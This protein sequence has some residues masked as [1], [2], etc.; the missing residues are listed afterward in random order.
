M[1]KKKFLVY[2]DILGFGPLAA[3]IA[4][5]KGIDQRMVRERFIEVIKGKIE[6]LETKEKIIGKKY[7]NSDDWIL[8]TDTLDKVF[9]CIYEIL[10]H[11]TGYISYEKIPLEIAMGIGGFDKWARFDGKN[12]IGEDSA[13]D[14]LKTDIIGHYRKWYKKN[15]N[16]SPKSTFIILTESAY[17][18][19]EPLDKKICQQIENKRDQDKEKIITFFGADVDKV[20]RGGKAYEFLEKI[21]YPGNK[22]YGKIDELYVPPFE[23]EDIKKTLEEKRIIFITGTQE[24]GKTYTAV[25]LLWEYYNEGYEPIWI[26]G[27]EQIQ[28]VEVRERL[29]NIIPELKPG[30]VI[31]FEDPFGKIK[32]EKREGLERE[33]GI[34]IESVKQVEDVFVIITSREEVFKEFEKEKISVKELEKFEHK[35]N[36]KNLS[37]DYEKRKEVLLK[38]AEAENC[39]WLKNKEL[40]EFVINYIKDETKLSTILS[41]KDFI[42]C[43]VN[44]ETESLLQKVL[45]KKSKETARAFVKEIKAM[46][47]DKILF[48]SFLF[49]SGH[50]EIDFIKKMFEDLVKELKIKDAIKFNRI[51]DWFKN[52]K[53]NIYL[54]YSA[55]NTA[56][57]SI[58]Y[59]GP[60]S[61]RCLE[62]SHISYYEALEYL[63]IEDGHRTSIDE[64]IFNKLLF[65]LAEEDDVADIIAES[66]ESHFNILSENVREKLLLILIEKEKAAWTI[67]RIVGLDFD[68]LSEDVRN[69]LLNKLYKNTGV[70]GHL[71]F[72]LEPLMDS[73]PEHIRD[74]LFFL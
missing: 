72:L 6:V 31:Y 57:F 71:A 25:R 38:L 44:K 68:K 21:G 19:L 2:L 60:N 7:G 65:R 13:I 22:W 12:L 49:I 59:G 74:E 28:R 14:F 45:E 42:K 3:K 23:Y 47:D 41:I 53:I 64:R 9:S 69:Q 55:F 34:I 52:D 62:F 43:S 1:D 27:G 56:A 20:I 29:E 40:K 5:E 17:Q 33:I 16:Q 70:Q 35:L 10:D 51:L 26:K 24:I 37:Y 54:K 61:V 63:L 66:V 39:M 11:N 67:T 73:L 8:V 18:E 36:L 4:S 48:L 58:D 46:T 32:Y 50:F 15:H 30:H